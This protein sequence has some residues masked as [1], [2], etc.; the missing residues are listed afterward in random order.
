MEKLEKLFQYQTIDQKL[1][2]IND[3]L[4]NTATRT[5]LQKIHSYLQ[6][7]QDAILKL[8]QSLIV[9]QNEVDDAG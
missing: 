5:R 7:Q 4:K 6:K 9:K 8:E 1:E 2:E 3:K